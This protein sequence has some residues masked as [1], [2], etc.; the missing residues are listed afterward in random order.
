MIP[1]VRKAVKGYEGL[2]HVTNKGRVYSL[3]KRDFM[4]LSNSR[5]HRVVN[6]TKNKTPTLKLVHKL[7]ME[8]FVGPCPR[9]MEVLHGPK[10]NDHLDNLS[11]GT[12]SQNI[13]DRNRDGVKGGP[14]PVKRSDGERF[15]SLT[16][17]AESVGG[18]YQNVMKCCKGTIHTHKNFGWEY[19]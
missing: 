17:A 19:A 5:Q 18:Q 3:R 9:G 7:V 15:P 4:K 1:E 11:Y 8:A 6:L 16:A 13:H 10:D 12:R 2:Y 14:R